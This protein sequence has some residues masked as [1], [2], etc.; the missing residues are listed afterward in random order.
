MA[1]RIWLLALAALA[2]VALPAGASTFLA[3]TED[4]L[5]AGAE[6]VV[7]GR[8]VEV[9]SFWNAERT[10]ILTEALVQVE[11][12]VAGDA[13]PL[14]R[15]RTF[16]GTVDGYTIEAHGFPTFRD[17]ER[18]LV[19]L[20]TEEKDASVRVLGYQ[21]GQF[22]IGVRNGVEMALPTVDARARLLLPDGQEGPA[23]RAVPLQQL[24]DRIRETAR[25]R[26]GRVR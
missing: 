26:G 12:V 1:R 10:A 23:P 16:G 21:Q 13:A 19:F 9:Q 18:L 3:M 2:A 4:E 7:Q 20:Y 22:R 5:V 24:K 8:V 14:V 6:A 25:E 15:V 17:G 11:E